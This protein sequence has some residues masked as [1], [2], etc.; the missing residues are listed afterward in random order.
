MNTYFRPKL[1][2]FPYFLPCLCT[3]VFAVV[4]LISCIWMPVC[5]IPLN[6]FHIHHQLH[7]FDYS[8]LTIMHLKIFSRRLCT[9]IKLVKMKTRALKLWRLIWLIQKK[10]L[11]K[12]EVW[13]PRRRAYSRIGHWCH[14][15]LSIASSPSMTWLTQRYLFITTCGMFIYDFR[16]NYACYERT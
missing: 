13:V 3:S 11:K 6:S 14:Q 8:V 15:Y 4:V 5:E 16:K 2:R 1:V 7:N 10:R 9:S 12:V